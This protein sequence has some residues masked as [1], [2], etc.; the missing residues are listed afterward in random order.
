M[1]VAAG[2]FHL[3]AQEGKGGGQIGKTGAAQGAGDAEG[4]DVVLHGLQN[5]LGQTRQDLAHFVVPAV[6]VVVRDQGHQEGGFFERIGDV[7]GLGEQPRDGLPA[8]QAFGLVAAP[9]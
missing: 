9:A 2:F 6:L 7:V 4:A 3:L 1:F 8:W 5:G